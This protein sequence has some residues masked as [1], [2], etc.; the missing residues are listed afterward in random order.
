V[1]KV[2]SESADEISQTLR[3]GC[4]AIWLQTPD[5]QRALT[6]LSA[7]SSALGRTLIVWSCVRGLHTLRSSTTDARTTDPL[8]AIE[9]VSKHEKRAVI[10][11]CDVHSF[12]TQALVLRKLKES[13]ALLGA[14]EC[15]IVVVAPLS[16][17]FAEL[18]EGWAHLSLPE[19][20]TSELS[21]T[22]DEVIRRNAGEATITVSASERTALL[23]ATRTL[24]HTALVLAL[25]RAL[26]GDPASFAARATS[27][28]LRA[29]REQASQGALLEPINTD[30]TLDGV[31][32][33]DALKRWVQ[34]RGKAFAPKAREFGIDPPRGVLIAGVQGTGKSL[35]AQAVAT[36]W[37]LP[38][39]R[40]EV[41]RMF[42]GLVGASEANM[43]RA[44]Y[45]AEQ[46][47][48]CV[49]WLDE[50][51][52][53]LGGLERGGDAGTSQR[54]LGY[55][56]T[57][58]Q[59]QR[60]AVFVVA[61]TNDVSGLP[62]ELMRKGRFDELFFV[63]LPAQSERAEIA[64]IHLSKRRRDPR[65]FSLDSVAQRTEGFCGADIEQCVVSAL[66]YAFADSRELTDADLL[67]AVR[68]CVPLSKTAGE[69][70]AALR[71]WA[72]GRARAAST[73]LDA[74]T[75]HVVV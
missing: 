53:A 55:L 74:Q 6:H 45:L 44:L 59:E 29:R 51:G 32:G 27:E 60:A 69:S 38:L 11:L 66:Y 5:E 16:N 9:H 43:R 47:A 28:C 14:N 48:P 33:L 7:L 63:D 64:A 24:S 73:A 25:K 17:P 26:L 21:A 36:S 58:L 65:N 13:I 75:A 4:A 37:K 42:Q 67:R 23:Q 52:R 34:L 1:T 72:H 10:A 71:K 70:I 49:L 31:G 62:P 46:C 39:L 35:C 56:L 18:Q 15:T 30:S 22:I 12:L 3:V 50:L 40:L 8:A 2:P 20:S 68:E 61:T 41:G 57:W 54:V 19:L